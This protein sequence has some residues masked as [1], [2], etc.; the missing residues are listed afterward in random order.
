MARANK[1]HRVNNFHIS[2]QPRRKDIFIGWLP[3][4]WPWCKLNMDG[5]CKHTGDTGAGGVIRDFVGHWISGFCMKIRENSVTMVE[6]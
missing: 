5:T 2:Q 6:L 1:I 3:S 4:P